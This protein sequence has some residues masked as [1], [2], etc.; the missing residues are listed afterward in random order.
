MLDMS[1][2]DGNLEMT[3]VAEDHTVKPTWKL[4]KQTD[5]FCSVKSQGDNQF[6]YFNI[7]W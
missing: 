6:W 7:N 3:T 4:S 1:P 5:I 2:Q